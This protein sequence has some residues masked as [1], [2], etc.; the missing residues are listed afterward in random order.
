[1]KGRNLVLT[2]VLPDFLLL[3][4]FSLFRLGH[5]GSDF[6]KIIAQAEADLRELLYV[7][8]SIIEIR[9]AG[10]TSGAGPNSFLFHF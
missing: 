4:C 10:I 3:L 1:M 2:V 8:L 7:L 6:G 5:R 9:E